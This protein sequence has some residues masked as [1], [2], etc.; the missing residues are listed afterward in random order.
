MPVVGRNAPR[1]QKGRVW[2]AWAAG[3]GCGVGGIAIQPGA[4][5]EEAGV[6]RQ[7]FCRKRGLKHE[8]LEVIFGGMYVSESKAGPY[9][10]QLLFCERKGIHESLG[11]H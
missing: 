2:G 3:H 5:A 1:E 7:V 9:L 4:G 11:N 10:P 8:S 6:R